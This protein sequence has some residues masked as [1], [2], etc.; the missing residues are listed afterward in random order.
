M[1]TESN[2]SSGYE[3][4][5]V[6]ITKVILYGFGGIA[7]LAVLVILVFDWFSAAREK[8]IY[9]AQ[10]KPESLALRQ[11]RA[12]EAE[13]LHSYAVIDPKKGMYRIPIDRAMEI[14]AEESYKKRTN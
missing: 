8:A 4:K 6:N 3:T 2:N 11:L 9:E 7:L 14:L 5:D 13:L 12:R 10:L 1:T